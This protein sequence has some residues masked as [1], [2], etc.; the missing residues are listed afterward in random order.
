[1]SIDPAPFGREPWLAELSAALDRALELVPELM[2]GGRYRLEAIEL[3]AR[4]EALQAEIRS[5]REVNL[6]PP[7][8]D[9]SPDRM[10]FAPF[11]VSKRCA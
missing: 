2:L 5:L 8:P 9:F 3:Y 6:G 7:F 4:I 1:M 10:Q 11:A